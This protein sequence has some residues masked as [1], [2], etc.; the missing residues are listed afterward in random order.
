MP[1]ITGDKAIEEGGIF[2]LSRRP[3]KQ[4][5]QKSSFG[6]PAPSSRASPHPS[7]L[8][9]ATPVEHFW[10]GK[11][12]Y[13]NQTNH[14]LRTYMPIYQLPYCTNYTLSLTLSLLTDSHSPLLVDANTRFFSYGIRSLELLMVSLWRPCDAFFYLMTF[15]RWPMLSGPWWFRLGC[16]SNLSRLGLD[17]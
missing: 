10:V 14:H 17:L 16:W 2:W 4:N 13:S 7:H 5:G 15:F 11:Q 12:H 3:I 6:T 1:L 8:S 9:P